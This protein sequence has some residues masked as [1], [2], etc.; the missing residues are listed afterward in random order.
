MLRLRYSCLAC[1]HGA[2]NFCFPSGFC[3]GL[4]AKQECRVVQATKCRAE[5]FSRLPGKAHFLSSSIRLS[6]CQRHSSSA[7]SLQSV[8][9]KPLP[10]ISDTTRQRSCSYASTAWRRRLIFGRMSVGFTRERGLAHHF[11]RPNCW[12]RLQLGAVPHL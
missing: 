6:L 4:L 1:L 7:F 12:L 2:L 10:I 5:S 9:E 8:E 3:A 11:F